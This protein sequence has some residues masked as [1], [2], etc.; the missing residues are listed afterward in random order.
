MV[1]LMTNGIVEQLKPFPPAWTK[2]F[3]SNIPKFSR[4]SAWLNLTLAP[5]ATIVE[6]GKGGGFEHLVGE[7]AVR[8]N[9][10]SFHFI[11]N[12]TDNR[13]G[14]R[15][16]IDFYIHDATR[17]EVQ[18]YA[19]NINA[20]YTEHENTIDPQMLWGNNYCSFT[21]NSNF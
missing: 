16:G 21:T 11:P 10:Q 4:T 5:G 1:Q 12:S 17:D 20:R 3:R 19:T 7:H 9:G 14:S 13:H 2:Y 18:S 15:G 6:N 8:M